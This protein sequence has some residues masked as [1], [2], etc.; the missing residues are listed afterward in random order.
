MVALASRSIDFAAHFLSDEAEF[1]TLAMPFTHS[2][3]EIAEM[4]GKA[5]LLLVDVEFLNIEDEFLFEA[6]LI[7]VHSKA[8][9]QAIKDTFAYFLRTFL[10]VGSNAMKQ[11]FDIIKFLLELFLLNLQSL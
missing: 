7:V 5:L 2:F 4:I 3:S 8:F 11:G 9:L 10:F 6:V 1:L